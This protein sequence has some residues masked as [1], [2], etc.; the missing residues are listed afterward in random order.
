MFT[1]KH[2]IAIAEELK[3]QRDEIL[4]LSHAETKLSFLSRWKVSVRGF[5]DMFRNDN[6]RFKEDTFYRACGYEELID[7]RPRMY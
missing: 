1:Q 6:P 7:N 3:R 4:A 5:V 2:Y